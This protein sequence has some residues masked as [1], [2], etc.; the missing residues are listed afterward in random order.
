VISKYSFLT[1]YELSS[2]SLIYRERVCNE[3][4]FV[5]APNLNLGQYHIIGK[6]GIVYTISVNDEQLVQYLINTCRHIP[7][8]I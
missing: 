4:V 2:A 1:V 8:V 6:E 3:N 7:E 5:G